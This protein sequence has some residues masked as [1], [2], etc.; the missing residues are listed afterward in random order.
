M[1]ENEEH[2]GEEEQG[3]NQDIR[4]LRKKAK[5][6]DTLQA[7]LEERERELAFAKASLDLNDP[8]MTY[9]M[10]GYEGEMTPE[11]IRERAEADGFLTA[12]KKED[13]GP[14]VQ[15]QQRLANASSGAGETVEPD[16][17][18]LL[19]QAQSPEDVMKLAEKHG[20]PTAWTRPS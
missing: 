4:N 14:E 9:F 6:Y 15:A 11:A 7:Q 3:G 2:E 20:V 12:Q 10:K 17:H 16:Y 13:T 5:E 19:S 18:D 1:P 8:K